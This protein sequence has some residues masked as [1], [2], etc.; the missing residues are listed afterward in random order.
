[1]S[2]ERVST[3]PSTQAHS[4]RGI[5]ALRALV[6]CDLVDSTA[7]LETLGDQPASELMRRHDRLSRALLQRYGGQEIDKTDGFLILFERPIE[8]V[9]FALNY[10]RALTEFEQVES[11]RLRARVGVHVGE[12]VLWENTSDDIDHGAKP[13]EVE[14]LAKPT[15]ARL[16]GLAGPGQTLLSGVAYSLAERSQGELSV[17]GARLRWRLHGAYRF[18]GVNEPVNVWEVGEDGIAPF[19]TPASSDKARQILPWWRRGASI[20]VAASLLVAA[21]G[22]PLYLSTRTEPAIAFAPRDWVVIGDLRNLTSD[23]NLTEPMET[24]FRV[25]LEQSRFVNVMSSLKVRQSLARMSRAP[26]TPLDRGAAAEI[27]LR[28]GAGRHCRHSGL[29]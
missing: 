28:E 27:A 11:V 21:F 8:A 29:T 12:V 15:A 4:G 14:G 24:A 5:S 23:P 25:S 3:A 7:L 17:H 26:E 20:A 9:G 13:L 18:K 1:M 22:L 10:H 19:S 2:I 16:M 6:L